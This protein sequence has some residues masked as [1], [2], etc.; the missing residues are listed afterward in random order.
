MYHRGRFHTAIYSAQK[1]VRQKKL[2][3]NEIQQQIPKTLTIERAYLLNQKKQTTS[4]RIPLILTYN[5][6]R[7]Y[8]K[9]AVNKHQD[10]LKIDKEFEHVFTELPII[11][12][13]RNRNL[14]DILGIK[15]I[16]NNRKQ[17]IKI[18]IKMFFRNSATPVKQ[19]MLST[20]AISKHLQKQSHPQNL[21][22]IQ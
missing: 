6:T 5:C 7:Q 1:V 15:T 17:H 19:F 3:E 8:I 10:I 14:Q 21:Q 9:R 2:N 16:V 11:A 22:N 12:F 20:T 4:S 18:L 13:R